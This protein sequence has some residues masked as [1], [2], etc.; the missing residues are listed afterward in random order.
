MAIEQKTIIEL[1]EYLQEKNIMVPENATKSDMLKLAFKPYLE[2]KTMAQLKEMLKE[3][4]ILGASSK[5]KN[6]LVE[7]LL[8]PF[9]KSELAE[10]E[11]S[12]TITKKS[13]EKKELSDK[14]RNGLAI[15]ADSLVDGV[16]KEKDMPANNSYAEKILISKDNLKQ[17]LSN[18]IHIESE[19]QFLKEYLIKLQFYKAENEKDLKKG[20]KYLKEKV[21]TEIKYSTLDIVGEIELIEHKINNS[22]NYLDKNI[23]IEESDVGIDEPV[24]P[25]IDKPIRPTM[26][27]LKTLVKPIMP[28][29]PN[30]QT[31]NFF[32]KKKVTLQNEE[33]RKEYEKQV[34]LYAQMLQQY[35]EDVKN[36]S[37]LQKIYEDEVAMYEE[38]AEAYKTMQEAYTK[39]LKKYNTAYEKAYNKACRNK[40]K[41]FIEICTKEL[42]NKKKELTIAEEKVS[43]EL[44]IA[45]K[46]AYTKFPEMQVKYLLTEQIE[47]IK[48]ELKEATKVRNEL[49]SYNVVYGKYRNYVA[50][51]TIYEYIDSGR[52]ETL[53]G[54]D[55]AYNLFE[56][57]L[58]ANLIISQLSSITTSLE[59]IKGNQFVLYKELKA[60]NKNLK[61]IDSSICGAINAIGEVNKNLEIVTDS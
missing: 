17:Y 31:P 18:L 38:E 52:C 37:Y 34:A 22:K 8:V 25:Q 19:I 3:Y 40:E 7:V 59:Q 10:T 28:N 32:N 46:M 13:F 2:K 35:E 27:T 6:E 43:D 12:H 23:K 56:T 55:G 11:S 42:E 48:K 36:N 57:E 9:I 58:R 54:A 53:E 24:L 29:K 20:E 16:K 4:N 33:L 30:Y 39:A 5:T 49:Y 60:V 44:D 47:I 41:R 15:K 50:M 61:N 1:K 45:L 21:P 26:P 51:S 14:A